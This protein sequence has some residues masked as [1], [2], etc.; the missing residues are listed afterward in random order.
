MGIAPDPNRRLRP[1][2]APV[3]PRPLW[4]EPLLYLGALALVL[5]CALVFGRALGFGLIA[6][7]DDI[8]IS[9]NPNLGGPSASRLAWAFSDWSYVR[10]YVPLGWT[11]LFLIDGFSGLS[12][13]AYHGAS[14]VLHVLN[15]L[16]VFWT[17]ARLLPVAL[18]RLGESRVL[19]ASLIGAAW[20]AVHPL[21]VEL[22]AWASG[23]LNLQGDFFLLASFVA[24]VEGLRS[25]SAPVRTACN[26]MSLVAYGFSILSYPTGLGFVGALVALDAYFARRE[27]AL[28]RTWAALVARRG[29]WL[30]IGVAGGVLAFVAEGTAT[31]IWK[32]LLMP[33]LGVPGRLVQVAASLA[34]SLEKIVL[35]VGLSPIY[36]IF[37]GFSPG[38]VALAATGVAGVLLLGVLGV[39]AH[40]GKWGLCVA[41]LSLI[42]PYLGWGAALHSPSDRYS[43]LPSVAFA[44]GLAWAAAVL[45]S[46]FLIPAI[47]GI[48]ALAGASFRLT[49]TWRDDMSLLGRVERETSNRDARAQILLRM[50]KVCFGRGDY[51]AAERLSRSAMSLAGMPE[52]AEPPYG[53]AASRSFGDGAPLASAHNGLGVAMVRAGDVKAAEDHFRAAIEISPSFS[54][55]DINLALLLAGRGETD[56]PLHLYLRVE[57]NP[58]GGVDPRSVSELL[59]R[60][61]DSYR[62]EG[63][64]RVADA[65]QERAAKSAT[66][67]RQGL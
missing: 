31:G 62:T 54:K 32:T 14:V 33:G 16:L 22:A 51:D 35:P 5:V 42:F 45:N 34:F 1:A 67:P 25:D 7:D 40:K 15:S 28:W 38:G 49:E 29:A 66:A 52:G 59:R 43:Y 61:G 2:I 13:A 60:L 21:R 39:L 55:A 37:V 36:D 9:F 24:A 3:S 63:R 18:P 64:Q 50:G 47:A 17:I 23:I 48:L 44:I 20:W 26:G 6:F 12:P 30:M 58:S 56:E 57:R 41:F 10:R 27:L 65:L 8:N 19:L 11:S 4:R 53:K 46:A